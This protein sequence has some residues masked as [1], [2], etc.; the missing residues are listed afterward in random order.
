MTHF[1]AYFLVWQPYLMPDRIVKDNLLY[2]SHRL[3]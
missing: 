1:V 2:Q 3:V